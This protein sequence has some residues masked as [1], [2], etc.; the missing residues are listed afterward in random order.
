VLETLR[1]AVAFTEQGS[2]LPWVMVVGLAIV[3][4]GVEAVGTILIYIVAGAATQPDRAFDLPLVGDLRDRFPGVNDDTLF[5]YLALAIAVFFVVRAVLFLSQ[6]Y[7]QNR[8]AYRTGLRIAS[9]LL[10]G[11]LRMP[12]A[13]HLR[14]NSAQMVRNAYDSSNKVVSYVLSPLVM[15]VSQAMV[16]LAIA[17]VLVIVAPLAMLLLAIVLGALVLGLLRF[18]QPRLAR[19]GT[20]SQEMS[21]RSIQALQQSLHGIRDIKLLGR[22]RFFRDQ[23]ERSQS[24][25]ARVQYAR[26]T[27]FEAPRITVETGVV[28]LLLAFLAVTGIATDSSDDSLALIGLFA[29]AALRLTPA[30]NRIVSNLNFIKFGAAAARDVADDLAVLKREVPGDGDAPITRFDFQREIAVERVSFRYEGSHRD[31]LHEVDLTISAG[32][33][34]GLVGSTGGG[35]TTLLDVVLGLLEPREGCVRVDGVDIRTN[36]SGWH[37]NLGLV[38]QA[39][40]L[41]DDTVRRNIALGMA[42]HEI[43]AVAV[44]EAVRMAQLDEFVASLPDGLDTVVGERGLRIS[45][46]QRQRVTIARALYRRPRVLVFDEGTSALDNRTEADLIRALESLR[47]QRT[48]IIV[49]HRLTTVRTCDRIVVLEN[50]RIIDVGTFHELTERSPM[51]RAIAR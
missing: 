51:F 11:Y 9:R 18:V 40:F 17:M 42:D 3:V 20:E 43:D 7:L 39:Q 45:G 32:E 19:L 16:V 15:L 46:G 37:A 21:K 48:M 27:F 31:V 38:P 33:S 26:Q 30:L 23:F 47:G 49:A 10:G 24:E 5:R 35:K 22:E 25:L 28:L 14:R 8:V 29:Y 2:R 1:R 36:L 6:V 13:W 34:V 4:S 41:M 50:G 44:A 12:Y